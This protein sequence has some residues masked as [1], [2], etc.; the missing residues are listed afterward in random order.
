MNIEIV[1]WDD[2]YHENY[3]NLAIEWLEKYVSVE[4][5]DLVILNDPY[6]QVLTN[7]GQILFAKFGDEIVGTVS[8]INTGSNTFELAK[9]CVTEKYKGLKIG[10]LLMEESLAFAKEMLAHRVILFTN[11]KL[12]PAIKLY[13]KLG[14]V[15]ISLDNNKYIESDMMM[16]LVFV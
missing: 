12:V 1:E 16:E 3:K 15:E 8:M 14:F 4:P 11:T 7:G 13:E 6:G 2:K 5:A 10:Q 9:L